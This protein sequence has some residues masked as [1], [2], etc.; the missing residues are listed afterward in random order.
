MSEVQIP[1]SPLSPRDIAG[2][3]YRHAWAMIV[4]YVVLVGGVGLY[5]F[6]WP[7]SYEAAVRFLVKN[8]RLEPIITPDQGELRTVTRSD[9]S[10]ADLNSE[11]AII[12]SGAVLEKTVRDLKLDTLPEHWIIRLVR[13][14]LERATDIYNRYHVRPGDT[15]VGR[16][17]GRLNDHLTVEPQKKSEIITVRL[18]WGH[19]AMAE[20]I[21]NTLAQNYLA[22]HLAVRKAPEAQ[23]FFEQQVERKKQEIAALDEQIA[24]IRPGGTSASVEAEREIATRQ[25]AEFEAEWRK[26]HALQAQSNARLKSVQQQLQPLPG[27]VVLQ[28]RTLVSAQTLDDL[29]SKVLDLQLRKTE[30]LQKFQPEQREVVQVANQLRQAQ[31]MLAAE[32]RRTYTEQTSGR[33]QIADTLGQDLMLTRAQSTSLAALEHATQQ[34]GQAFAERLARLG[35][36][37]EQ[38]RD[39]ERKRAALSDAYLEYGRRFEEARVNDEL[40]RKGFANVEMIEPVRSGSSP[41]KPAIGLLMKIALGAGLVVSIAVA[42]VLDVLDHRVK[43]ERD[44]EAA[45]RVP[46]LTVFDRYDCRRDGD[47]EDA[48][49]RRA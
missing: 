9:V 3:L 11:A 45:I 37:A 42:F 41:V 5:C 19:P 16:A 22:Q 34:E 13:W 17:T 29:K 4:C 44:L 38:L 39:L 21:L 2:V 48:L 15:P 26:A 49:D 8:D 46:V 35:N 24:A 10:E 1:L 6:F 7:P 33:N 47:E 36:E 32:E 23:A 25:A 12:Q 43:G 27:T 30:L 14:P 18:T 20:T 28:D 40:H 31:D